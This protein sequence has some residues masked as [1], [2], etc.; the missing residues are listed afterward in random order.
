MPKIPNRQPADEPRAMSD[1]EYADHLTAAREVFCDPAAWKPSR[2]K[3]GN[4]WRH[5]DG[6]TLTVFRR[7]DGYYGW[8]IADEFDKRYSRIGYEDQDAAM[9]ALSEELGVGW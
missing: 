5:W 4:V 7:D 2:R 8:C 3:P 9:G 1:E 6:I